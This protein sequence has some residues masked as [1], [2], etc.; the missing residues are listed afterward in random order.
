M[1]KVIDLTQGRHAIIDSEDFEKVKKYKWHLMSNK[2]KTHFYARCNVYTK[3]KGKNI[4]LHRLIMNAEKGKLVDHKDGDGLN[5]KKSNLRISTQA[6]NQQNRKKFKSSTGYKNV[7]GKDRKTF[8]YTIT[9]E[10]KRKYIGN[11]T[12]AVDAARAYDEHAKK[13]FG[14]FARLNFPENNV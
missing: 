11:F 2:A 5:C 1:E 9:V 10:G 12:K 13:L 7:V 14:E 3:G 8:R 4:Y 6:Q